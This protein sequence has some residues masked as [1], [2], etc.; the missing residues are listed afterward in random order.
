[1]GFSKLFLHHLHL[2][3][4]FILHLIIIIFML[5]ILFLWLILLNPFFFHQSFLMNK[6]KRKKLINILIK[7]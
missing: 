2:Y 5:M 1:M 7:K 3:K 6:E 4:V